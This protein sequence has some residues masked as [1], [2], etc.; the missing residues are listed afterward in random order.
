MGRKPL[1]PAYRR[2]KDAI[3][4]Q[5]DRYAVE[6]AG[7]PDLALPGRGTP[8]RAGATSRFLDHSARREAARIRRAIG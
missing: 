3:S 7:N 8:I 1:P 6:M 2:L 5:A 4:E